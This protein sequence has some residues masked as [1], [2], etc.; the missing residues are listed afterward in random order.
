MLNSENNMRELG[1]EILVH[2]G[3]V[4]NPIALGQIKTEFKISLL[5]RVLTEL[6]H[7]SQN[8]QPEDGI[9]IY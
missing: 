4:P 7:C 2:F 3:S 8:N 9:D 6:T 5:K 1:E